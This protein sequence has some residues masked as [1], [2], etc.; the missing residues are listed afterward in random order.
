MKAGFEA[1]ISE[2]IIDCAT[3]LTKEIKD[4]FNS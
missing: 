4:S 2:D 3:A 1:G